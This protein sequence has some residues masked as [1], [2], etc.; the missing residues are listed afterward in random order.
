MSVFGFKYTTT[1]TV[2]GK[3]LT[4]DMVQ[5]GGAL[6]PEALAWLEEHWPPGVRYVF[7][8]TLGSAQD[9][10]GHPPDARE[11]LS[12]EEANARAQSFSGD[13]WRIDILEEQER[14]HPVFRA[15]QGGDWYP[16]IRLVGDF[17]LCVAREPQAT[18]L[19]KPP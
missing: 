15:F 13:T 6:L 2:D 9:V 8:L 10:F 3:P 7:F 11:P 19:Q 14:Y 1:F 17:R 4:A 18:H 5:E 16:L 12:V